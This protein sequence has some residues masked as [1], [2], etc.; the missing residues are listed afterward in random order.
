VEIT[1]KR[2]VLCSSLTILPDTLKLFTVSAK[3][4]YRFR[5][6]ISAT[7]RPLSQNFQIIIA[8]CKEFLVFLYIS[9]L[10]F[11]IGPLVSE[12]L[13]DDTHGTLCR[14]EI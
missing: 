11:K 7:L 4:P 10:V 14:F 9:I 5:V 3:L 1:E 13:A 12:T 6:D 2:L 8:K